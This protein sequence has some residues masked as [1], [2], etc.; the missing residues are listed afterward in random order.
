M[1]KITFPDMFS[2]YDFNSL[3]LST[4]I[5]LPGGAFFTKISS[6][7]NDIYIQTP[8]CSSK[9]GFVKSG[10]KIHIDLV[11]DKNNEL[12]CQFIENLENT[13]TKLIY[14]KRDE[15][16][17]EEV[18][19]DDI[20]NAFTNT[21]KSYKSGSLFLLRTMLDSPRMLTA[22]TNLTIYDQQENLVSMEDITPDTNMIPIIQ[23]H[24]LKFTAKNFQIY[25]QIKQAMVVKNNLFNTCLIKNKIET[26]EKSENNKPIKMSLSKSE[27]HDA[28]ENEDDVEQ[29]EEETNPIIEEETNPIIEEE[30]TPVIEEEITPVIEEESAPVIE[31]KDET[32][33]N[34]IINHDVTSQHNEE[35]LLSITDTPNDVNEENTEQTINVDTNTL[36]NED[37]FIEDDKKM[38]TIQKIENIKE[39]IINLEE[40][41][42]VVDNED[43]LETITL[44][45]PNDIYLDMYK[46]F[47]IKAREAR[48]SAL[49]AY[50]EAKKIKNVHMLDI[51]DS[52][53]NEY[54]KQLETTTPNN[55]E[56]LQ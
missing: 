36:D 53:D 15:W 31:P 39:P 26:A 49:L 54:E 7:S 9:Q 47:R 23:L 35:I 46:E 41:D 10:R 45:K 20:E 28:L 2:N 1:D 33:E 44:K 51:D 3:T 14:D 25:L 27:P 22:S 38:D 42:V 18:E 11:Y 16:F 37:V 56:K 32:S 34:E 6:N 21:L 19:F 50:L 55:L 48:K 17:Q 5:S 30:I 40:Y 12:F 24:G 8:L 29:I 52:S 13:L 43:N 4:P